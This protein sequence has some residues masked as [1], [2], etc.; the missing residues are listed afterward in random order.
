MPAKRPRIADRPLWLNVCRISSAC[1][2][3]AETFDRPHRIATSLGKYICK[4][5][6]AA[7][8]V[9][10]SP[11]VLF[12]SAVARKPNSVSNSKTGWRRSFLWD[13]RCRMSQATYPRSLGDFRRHAWGVRPDSAYLV[14]LTVGFTLPLELPPARCAL[15][16]PFHPYSSG[17]PLGRYVFCGTF[18][19][20]APPRR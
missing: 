19:R 18:R 10:A 9:E 2:I 7:K 4:K 17:F 12:A 14:L 20:I 5:W 15:T 1:K 6:P 16:A 8:L 11:P 13:T 3:I